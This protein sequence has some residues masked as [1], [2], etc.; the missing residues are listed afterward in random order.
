MRLVVTLHLG[1]RRYVTFWLIL[2]IFLPLVIGAVGA[3][4][5][6][7]FLLLALLVP[8]ALLLGVGYL[9]EPILG[10]LGLFRGSEGWDPGGPTI[11]GYII[12]TI[13]IIGGVGLLEWF[14]RR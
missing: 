5:G 11:A 6:I 12:L 3:L 7:D 13:F 9:F 14:I 2:L 8:Y 1:L 10:A 4:L